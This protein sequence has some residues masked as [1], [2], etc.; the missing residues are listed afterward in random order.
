MSDGTEPGPPSTAYC[1]TISVAFIE[2]FSSLA[3]CSMA[4]HNRG[5]SAESGYIA[6]C[7]LLALYT[8]TANNRESFDRWVFMMA[9][10]YN[11]IILRFAYTSRTKSGNFGPVMGI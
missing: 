6:A 10:S 1:T 3:L 4:H 5:I 11:C 2:N 9:S 8:L 7:A